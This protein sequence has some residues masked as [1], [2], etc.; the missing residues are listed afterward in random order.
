MVNKKQLKVSFGLAMISLVIKIMYD[1]LQPQAMS[2]QFINTINIIGARG[3]WYLPVLVTLWYI[4][5]F[6]FAF[7]LFFRI[8]NAIIHILIR[9][10]K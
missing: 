7:Y 8:L 10:L 9:R 4:I 3:Y 5:A 6:T 1:L 2:S